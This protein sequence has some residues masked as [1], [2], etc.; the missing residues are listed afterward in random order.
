MPK[1][2]KKY[3]GIQ[4]NAP[5]ET[6]ELEEA[7]KFLKAN[8]AAKFDETVELCLKMGLDPK[9]S[10]H[11]VRGTCEAALTGRGPRV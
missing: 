7:L 10:E 9:R 2:G 8:P 1:H 3:R 4:E 5:K 6:L 11:A